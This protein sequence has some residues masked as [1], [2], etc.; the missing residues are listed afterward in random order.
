[1]ADDFDDDDDFVES[2]EEFDEVV[3]VVE[4]I[5]HSRVCSPGFAP[6]IIDTSN[7]KT[8]LLTR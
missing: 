5:R 4:I 7:T 3:V 2:L 6:G 1:M 8:V